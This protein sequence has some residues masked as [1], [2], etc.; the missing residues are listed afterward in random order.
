[1]DIEGRERRFVPLLKES[2]HGK[3]SILSGDGKGLLDHI[4]REPSE[5]GHKGLVVGSLF[6]DLMGMSIIHGGDIQ[7]VVLWVR[8]RGTREVKGLSMLCVDHDTGIDDMLGG[9][10]AIKDIM[11]LYHNSLVVITKLIKCRV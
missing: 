11:V 4:S 5:H 10:P 9:V 6:V 8:C 3:V 7:V 1:M 2:A